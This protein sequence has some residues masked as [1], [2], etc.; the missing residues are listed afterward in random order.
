MNQ[1]AL[2]YPYI[3]IHD[4]NWLKATLLLFS[5]VRRML[6]TNFSPNDD[7]Q[8]RAFTQ[9]QGDRHPLL[10]VANLWSERAAAAQEALAERLRADAAD[11]DFLQK[12]GYESARK[13][14]TPEDHGFQIHQQKLT[15]SLQDALR[16]TRLA[17]Q[18]QNPEPYWHMT[19]YVELH[20]RVGEAVMSTL[21]IAA[22]IGEGLDIVGDQ[23]SGP[24]HECLLERK[25]EE[26]YSAWLHPKPLLSPPP[27]ADAQDVFEFLVGFCCDLTCVKPE[28]LAKLQDD[29]EPLR[30]LVRHLQTMAAEIPRTDNGRDRE[31]YFHDVAARTLKGWRAD[32]SNMSAYWRKFFG[33]GMIDTSKTFLEKVAG[34]LVAGSEKAATGGAAAGA[35]AATAA[36]ASGI[37]MATAA[38]A[39]AGVGLAIGVVFHGAKS[40][41]RMVSDEQNSPYRY[42]AL[43]EQA[44]VVFR[45]DIGAAPHIERRKPNSFWRRLKNFSWG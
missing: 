12:Y 13:S 20:Q 16:S 7:E 17:W 24:L 5:E 39:G 41:F 15:G 26:V 29:R 25:A 23:R 30:K 34:A 4:V 35:T 14:L 22:A 8:V 43:M 11:K 27:Q 44:G 45:G 21:A 37:S 19:E 40:Y 10:S 38:I 28:A 3:H 42:L 1:K 9:W 36:G 31:Q 32:R 33:E 6:P 18:P 2:Y